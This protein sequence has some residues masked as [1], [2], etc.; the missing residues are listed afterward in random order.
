MSAPKSID[1][2]AWRMQQWVRLWNPTSCSLQKSTLR[3][4]LLRLNFVKNR[5]G[6]RYQFLYTWC[7]FCVYILVVRAHK[8]TY[9]S[10]RFLCCVYIVFWTKLVLPA[11]VKM[12]LIWVKC[13]KNW[14]S[15][16]ERRWILKRLQKVTSRWWIKRWVRSNFE[17]G[18]GRR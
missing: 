3:H 15:S 11:H 5:R 6:C 17:S 16:E 4:F 1:P 12:I 10:L 9:E 8:L 14:N 7:A 2:A 18:E 13:A